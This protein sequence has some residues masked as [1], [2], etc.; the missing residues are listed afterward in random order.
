ME[1]PK[2]KPKWK[3]P[4]SSRR[5][6]HHHRHLQPNPNKPPTA[7]DFFFHPK[8][9]RTK[10]FRRFT[11]PHLA[12]LDNQ[13]MH[14]LT[15][16][17]LVERGHTRATILALPPRNIAVLIDVCSYIFSE[18]VTASFRADLERMC[19]EVGEKMTMEGGRAYECLV[20]PWGHW[21]GYTSLQELIG[22]M[23]DSVV[24]D[25]N[26]RCE[27]LEAAEAEMMMMRRESEDGSLV[28]CVDGWEGEGQ[29]GEKEEDGVWGFVKRGSRVVVRFVKKVFCKRE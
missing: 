12:R 24:W 4:T 14:A 20:A 17:Y 18:T 7:A 27:E 29:V 19:D 25:Y 23:V 28:V 16:A 3:R 2:K 10:Q 15:L 21:R 1:K 22:A 26:R 8:L 5:T 13:L 11:R 6:H 9:K